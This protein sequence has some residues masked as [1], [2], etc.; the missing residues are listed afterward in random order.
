MFLLAFV[1]ISGFSLW[2]RKFKSHSARENVAVYM[3]YSGRKKRH[4]VKPPH[5]V[6]IIKFGYKNT[7]LPI[8]VRW[9]YFVVPVKNSNLS[10]LSQDIWTLSRVELLKS[11]TVTVLPHLG[12][13]PAEPLFSYWIKFSKN[14]YIKPLSFKS[15]IKAF[16]ARSA[17][18]SNFCLF[19]CTCFEPYSLYCSTWY[20]SW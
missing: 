2:Q 14:I 19:F 3:P 15:F 9:C 13:F 10:H 20:F 16:S 11:S 1:F 18:S 17:S 12:H 4:Y 5:N 7:T 8:S 6:L